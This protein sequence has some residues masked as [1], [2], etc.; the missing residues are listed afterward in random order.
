MSHSHH[1][2][3]ATPRL[4]LSGWG[5][6][7]SF[8]MTAGG[9]LSVL[10]LLVS[11]K[12]GVLFEF[13][14]SWL[15]AFM[16]FYSLAIGAL[17]LVMIHHLSGAA[18]SLGPRRFCEHIASLLGWPLVL[19]FIPV[20]LFGHQIYQ[21]MNLDPAT[22]N[23]VAA[24]APV[25]TIPGFWITSG[26]FFALLWF[27]SSRL[28][29]LSIEQDQTG[30]P[31]CTR[32]MNF[33]SGW[34]IVALSLLLTFSS[35][36]WMKAVQYQFFSCIYGVYFFSDCAWIALA[37][38]YVVSV[39]LYRQG[40][41][42]R[43]LH[44]H[45]FQ[46]IALLLF[47]FT[48]FSAYTEFAQYFV[49]WNANMPEETFWYL[50]REHGN[51]WTLGLVLIFGHFFVPFFVL[52]PL[53]IKT[54]FKVIVPV[55][56]LV[57]FMHALDL[58]FN[59][60]PAHRPEGYHLRWIWLPVGVFMFMGGFLANVFLMRFHSHAAY[61]QRDPRLLEAM[62]MNPNSIND[63]APNTLANTHS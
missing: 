28:S 63:L 35:V 18:W 52:L 62:G 48:L 43:V 53:K 1:H 23:L 15:L 22:N 14:C 25:F 57:A 4:D 33:H 26:I 45:C 10:G 55:C 34:G 50:I 6:L 9:L 5:F 8:L 29:S 27:L 59:I 30:A 39:I 61:P 60:F 2:H 19:M 3:S 51:W 7:P 47:G 13:G 37:T 44:E 12:H 32:K 24:K 36:L 56:I 41:L 21:W 38:V 58:A 49:V 46:N 42:S 17:F 40:A 11:W 31:S 20:G 54:N 16:F